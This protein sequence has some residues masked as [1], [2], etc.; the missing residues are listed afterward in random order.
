[1]KQG[2]ELGLENIIKALESLG[3]PHLSLKCIHVAG[4]N[5]K[6]SVVNLIST[7]LSSKY[8][9]GTFT[10]PHFLVP[11][12]AI[13]INNQPISLQEYNSHYEKT[14]ELKL[15]MF[16]K[17]V[18]VAVLVFASTRPDV[19][20]FEVGMGGRLD[21]TN[22]IQPIFCCI[23][24]IGL[25]HTEF[26]G[27]TVE[28]I[29]AE[30]AGIVKRGC[31]GVVIGCQQFNQ[32]VGILA[33]QCDN[34]NVE[35]YKVEKA[36][37]DTDSANSSQGYYLDIY[38]NTVFVERCKAGEYELENAALVAKLLTL[39]SQHGFTLCN[40][41]VQ[42]AFK[43]AQLL[44][45]LS[46]HVYRNSRVLVDGCHNLQSCLKLREHLDQLNEHKIVFI[47][48][49]SG[50]RDYKILINTVCK[51]DP[52]YVV[53]FTN[54][55]H[56]PWVSCIEPKQ[57]VDNMP[58]C[59]FVGDLEETLQ[60]CASQDALIVVFGSLYLIADFYRLKGN[61]PDKVGIMQDTK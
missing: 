18:V 15:T 26:L 53:Q 30:K 10:S 46:W 8:K 31:T 59:H 4:T 32:V 52:A 45:R 29:A 11:N 50:K 56:M 48:A 3:N 19:C 22:I 54:P 2:I 37:R 40:Q 39:L 38:N 12:D 47:C 16:E 36:I 17:E 33:K 42:V 60:E 7:A 55:E 34:M 25:D 27:D 23:T 43:E 49:F 5:G 9:I 20:I 61:F 6:G 58:T 14:R 28:L 57:V 13:K 35:Y 1:M 41:Q 51:N 44:G 21:A 24:N